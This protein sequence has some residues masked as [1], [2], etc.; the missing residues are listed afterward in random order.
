MNNFA[1]TM[2]TAVCRQVLCFVSNCAKIPHTSN[3][4]HVLCHLFLQFH[5]TGLKMED[6][7]SKVTKRERKEGGMDEWEGGGRE[8]ERE[9]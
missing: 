3:V 1:I 8:G 2:H 7:F 4:V 5:C 9:G 6:N